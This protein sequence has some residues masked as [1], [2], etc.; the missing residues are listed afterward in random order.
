MKTSRIAFVLTMLAIAAGCAAKQ[1]IYDGS[2]ASH[3]TDDYREAPHAQ[4]ANQVPV[5]P[6]ATIDNAMG[7]ESYG[8]E[9]DSHSYGMAWWFKTKATKDDLTKFYDAALPGARKTTL[10]NGATQ[11]SLAPKGGQPG[12]EIG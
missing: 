8:D 6:G 12:E 11:W 10:E 2:V 4:Y 1:P 5:Y 9:P 3:S 7:S